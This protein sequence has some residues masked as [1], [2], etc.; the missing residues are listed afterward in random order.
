MKILLLED[1]KTLNESIKEYL[2]LESFYVDSAYSAEEAYDLTFENS[3]DLYIFDINLPDENGFEILKNLK[4]ANDNTPAIYISALTD[5]QNISKA[6]GIGADDY[7][8]KPFDP[9]ELVV[10]I[11]SRY[12]KEDIIKYKDIVY[13]PLTKELT[14]AGKTITLGYVGENIID[15]LFRNLSRVVKDEDLMQF[16]NKPSQNALRVNIKRLKE[17]LDIDIKNIRMQ[18]YIIE[19]V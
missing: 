11:K 5:T 8:K 3:Y 16:L 13:N 7:I 15:L 18:G 17:K 1:D 10:R 19:K 9:E 6:F 2:E 12:Q 4:N 14:K